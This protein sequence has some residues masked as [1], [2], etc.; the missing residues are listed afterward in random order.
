M[1]VVR[2]IRFDNETY[3][4]LVDESEKRR[5]SFQWLVIKLVEE[6]LVR[7]ADAEEFKVTT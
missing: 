5:V 7:L 1:A 4:Q 3:H 6:G 2:S